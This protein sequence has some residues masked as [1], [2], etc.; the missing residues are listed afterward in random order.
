MALGAVLLRQLLRRVGGRAGGKGGEE[1]SHTPVRQG[2][3]A[4]SS[5]TRP[6]ASAPSSAILKNVVSTPKGSRPAPREYLSEEYINDHLKRFDGGA[7]R[8]MTKKNYDKYGISQSDG[9][10]FIMPKNEADNLTEMIKRDPRAAERNLGL[11]E[12]SLSDTELVR[13]D[14]ANPRAAGL[15]MPSGNEAGANAQWLPGG[16]LP[17]GGNE[18]VI[19]GANLPPSATSVRPI[20][21]GP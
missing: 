5:P 11:P 7:S 14:I 15:R 1:A 2:S 10:S 9:T 13:V 6:A 12:D 16:K 4:K 19:D 3:A 18:A 8:I 20:G 17:T 21:E